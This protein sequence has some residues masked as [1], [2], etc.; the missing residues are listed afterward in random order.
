MNF[1]TSCILHLLLVYYR[2]T[3][4]PAP[5]CLDSSVGR[6]LHPYRRGQGFESCSKTNPKQTQEIAAEKKSMNKACTV[7]EV[8]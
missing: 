6:A 2:L 1:D 3:K 7:M 4:W 8:F 5:S